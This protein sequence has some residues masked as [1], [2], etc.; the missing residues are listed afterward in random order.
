MSVLRIDGFAL[1]PIRIP[2][3]R[4]VTWASS[5]E[6][7]ADYMILELKADGLSGVAEGTVKLTFAGETLKTLASAFDDIFMPRLIDVDASDEQAIATALGMVREHRLARAM[8]DLAVW[9]L[10]AQAAGRPLWRLL[11]G[12]SPQVRM[13]FTVTRDSPSEMARVALRAVGGHRIAMLK[14]KTGQGIA[15]DA[16]ALD[17][18]RAAVGTGYAFYAD[19]NRAYRPEDVAPFTAM[20]AERGAVAAEDPCAL[21]PDRA[22]TAIRGRS[23]VPLLVDGPCRSL[24]T[25]ALFIEAGAQ[26]LSVKTGKTGITESLAIAA[27]A[28]RAGVRAHVGMQA[29]ADLGSLAAATLAS[30]LAGDGRESWLP[31]E[32]SYFLQ[33]PQGALREPLAITTGAL[34]LPETPGFAP[35]VDWDKV[36]ALAP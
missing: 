3:G 19:S 26:A 2:L 29:E 11:G 35:L 15:R 22:F 5:S 4:T 13:S 17:A 21:A 34:A 1:H 7:H 36:R 8:V 30:A 12:G 27:S 25:A 28:R 18:I 32:S 20:L 23:R 10:R 6:S 24:E 9:D 33:L 16:E 14:V 31:S